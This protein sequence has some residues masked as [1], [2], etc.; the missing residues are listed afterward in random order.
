MYGAVIPA[1]LSH[2]LG[3]VT[4]P[5]FSVPH[6]NSTTIW[7]NYTI[8]FAIRKGRFESFLL[9]DYNAI[10]S[11][12]E[13]RK[14]SS[15]S[16]ALKISSH[17]SWLYTQNQQSFLVL[18][19]LSNDGLIQFFKFQKRVAALAFVLLLITSHLQPVPWLLHPPSVWICLTCFLALSYISYVTVSNIYPILYF[20]P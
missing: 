15:S 12:F 6:I 4:F 11:L 1:L 10:L 5:I 18:E 16:M 19:T 2:F 13:I 14:H 20:W 9:L 7:H 8:F 3:L 17:H